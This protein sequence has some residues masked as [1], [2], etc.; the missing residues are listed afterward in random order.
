MFEV[1][2]YQP[3]LN[4]LVFLYNI[5][6][7]HDIGVVIIV[8]T[9]ILKLV[10]W[11][12]SQQS[13][14]SQKALQTLQPKIEELKKKYADKKDE[15]GKAMMLLYKENKVNPLSSC[16]PLLI[17]M[18][19]LFAVFRVFSNGLSNGSLDLVYP[20]ITK[21]EM[22]NTISFGFINLAER[23]IPF[24]ILAGLAQFWQSKMLIS[25]RPE[26]KTPEAKDEDM[27]SI[28]NKQMTYFMP[29][30]TV[31]IGLSFPGGLS[32]YWLVTTLLT[33]LQQKYIFS[34]KDK[35]KITNNVIEGEVIK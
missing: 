22:I 33:G 10:L 18:P 1:L 5:I 32:L 2:F 20:F 31:F 14:K 29:I 16:L 6:P 3:I 34:K 27:A 26:I 4:L 21:P 11:P 23:S 15:L 9:I 35:N 28:M 13:L 17:Q 7:G 25:K 30:M 8:L 24:A 12:L 19:F